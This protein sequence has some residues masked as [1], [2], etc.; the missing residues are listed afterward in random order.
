V[1]FSAGNLSL[2]S[3][4]NGEGKADYLKGRS[5]APLFSFVIDG[6]IMTANFRL[7][8][9][10]EKRVGGERKARSREHKVGT[11]CSSF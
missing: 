7:L 3:F 5:S 4:S 1:S 9:S 10:A 2:T 11:G 8:A 6:K